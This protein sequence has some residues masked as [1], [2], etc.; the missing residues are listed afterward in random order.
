MVTAVGG[1]RYH[2][3][4]AS[5]KIHN[6][7]QEHADWADKPFPAPAPEPK[8]NPCC[9][10]LKAKFDVA[11][12]NLQA[13]RDQLRAQLDARIPPS[14]NKGGRPRKADPDKSKTE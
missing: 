3:S 5:K 10:A 8:L 7:D 12:E 1:M 6:P 2:A 9:L 14:A 4:G 11:W 13:E